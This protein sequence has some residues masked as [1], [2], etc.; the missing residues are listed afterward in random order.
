MK[1][2]RGFTVAV[3]LSMVLTLAHAGSAPMAQ[4]ELSEQLWDRTASAPTR[5]LTS[6]RPLQKVPPREQLL[7]EIYSHRERRGG[8]GSTRGGSRGRSRRRTPAPTREPPVPSLP[9]TGYPTCPIECQGSQ[10][11]EA[12]PQPGDLSGKGT[13]AITNGTIPAFDCSP[14]AC[15]A[16]PTPHPTPELNLPQTSGTGRPSPNT[17]LVVA[18]GVTGVGILRKIARCLCGG[19][20]RSSDPDH[21]HKGRRLVEGSGSSKSDRTPVLM[22][23]LMPKINAVRVVDGEPALEF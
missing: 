17:A 13:K 1:F 3:A 15:T 5:E 6:N 12:L 9:P 14:F 7:S 10:N 21:V 2:P 16:P 19:K 20:R 4:A 22:G 23:D 11:Q 8:R 18:A